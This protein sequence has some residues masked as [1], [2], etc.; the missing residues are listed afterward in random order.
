MDTLDSAPFILGMPAFAAAPRDAAAPQPFRG[1]AFTRKNA[2]LG[3]TRGC[4]LRFPSEE[5]S[6]SAERGGTKRRGAVYKPLR[7][8]G[9]HKAAEPTAH[10]AEATVNALRHTK[11]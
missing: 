5:R 6:G 7:D 3:P 11:Q 2:V 1:G 9:G 10:K 4:G 8:N